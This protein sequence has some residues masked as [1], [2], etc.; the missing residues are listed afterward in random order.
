M[1]RVLLFG[2]NGQLGLAL[3]RAKLPAGWTLKALSRADLDLSDTPAIEAAI[4]AFKPDSIINAAAYTAVDKA[5]SEPKLAFA[6]NRDAPA[7]MAR[8]ALGAPLIH[9]STDYV[10]RGDKR[11]PY[12]ETDRRDPINTYG[13]SKA[14]GEI[15]VLEAHARATIVR[16]SWIFSADRANFLK[17]MLRLA[18]TRDEVAVVSDQR[19]R[20]TAAHD[21]ARAC[22][23]LVEQHLAGDSHTAGLFHFA[24]AGETSWAEFAEAIFA[25]AASRGRRP[26]HVRRVTTGDFPTPAKRPVNSSLDTTKIEALGI[27]PA[28][29]RDGAIMCLDALL[30]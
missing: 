29:W 25:E 16:T 7:A 14:E 22:I 17:T 30:R 26:V 4:A 8:A 5:E 6:L 11:T 13:R 12:L 3:R 18:E 27:A 24:G 15:A 1:T 19:G 20:P 2:A 23:A 21:L 10:F 9:I 28:P